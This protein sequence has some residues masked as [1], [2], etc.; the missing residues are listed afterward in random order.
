[1][2]VFSEDIPVD[3]SEDVVT[4]A[5]KAIEYKRSSGGEWELENVFSGLAS[6]VFI[7]DFEPAFTQSLN[8]TL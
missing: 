6:P 3:F 4:V 1:M 2:I 5:P 7:F 8:Q